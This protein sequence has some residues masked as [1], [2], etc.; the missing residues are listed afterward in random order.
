MTLDDGEILEGW[1]LNTHTD[2]ILDFTRLAENILKNR[3][4]E[5]PLRTYLYGHSAGAMLGRLINYVPGLNQDNATGTKYIDGVLHEDSGG[6]RYLPILEDIGRVVLFANQQERQRFV[7]SIALTHQFYI[8]RRNIDRSRP[9]CVSPA[10]LMN[11]RMY[12]NFL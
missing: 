1:N 4:G 8:R 6:G 12:S 11:I 5:S 7:K 10:Y 3:L 9:H 2:L